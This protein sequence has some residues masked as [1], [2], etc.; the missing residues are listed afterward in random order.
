MKQVPE[1]KRELERNK[2]IQQLLEKLAG[3]EIFNRLRGTFDSQSKRIDHLTHLITEAG[4]P[5]SFCAAWDRYA[6]DVRVI[7]NIIAQL[8]R[9]GC[10]YAANELESALKWPGYMLPGE[11]VLLSKTTPL[12]L[13]IIDF[14]KTI[15]ML[16][17][18]QAGHWMDLNNFLD[19]KKVNLLAERLFKQ[20]PSLQTHTV[21]R[22]NSHK[23]EGGDLLSAYHEDVFFPFIHDA[24]GTTSS[25][26]IPN[27]FTESQPMEIAFGTYNDHLEVADGTFG[28]IFLGDQASVLSRIPRKHQ[29]RVT[30][31]GF[32]APKITV[33]EIQKDRRKNFRSTSWSYYFKIGIHPEIHHQKWL[34]MGGAYPSL[35]CAHGYGAVLLNKQKYSDK[36]YCEHTGDEETAII[37]DPKW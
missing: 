2:Q 6:S 19:G 16:T 11:T 31:F 5:T 25:N 27:F 28:Y 29:H 35:G 3:H 30:T 9:D 4:S 7:G 32:N 24:F 21:K 12:T 10:D 1:E 33:N 26:E 20:F 8:R 34:E 14:P 17:W 22:R 23:Y 18:I 36:N 37:L 15:A 13:L